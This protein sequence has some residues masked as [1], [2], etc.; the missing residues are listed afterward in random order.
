MSP[1]ALSV[2]L[3]QQEEISDLKVKSLEL[4]ASKVCPAGP[5]LLPPWC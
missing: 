1:L 3:L 2:G 4:T 5:Q